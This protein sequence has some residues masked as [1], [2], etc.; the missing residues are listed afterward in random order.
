MVEQFFF[1]ISKFNGPT[2]ESFWT[3]LK[4]AT[5]GVAMYFNNYLI[6]NLYHVHAWLNFYSALNACYK[7]YM[8]IWLIMCIT[9]RKCP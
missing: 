9:I 6:T 5:Q 1:L 4:R 3:T 8:A 2:Q 7:V